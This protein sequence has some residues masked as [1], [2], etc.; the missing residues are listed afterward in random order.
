MLTRLPRFRFGSGPAA[1]VLAL[2]VVFIASRFVPAEPLF[3]EPQH[4]LALHSALEFFSIT[5]AGMVFALG[6]NLRRS[7]RGARLAWLG[8]VFLAVGLID[9]GHT[10]SYPGMPVFVTPSS[11]DKAIHFWLAARLVA[12]VGLLLH[13]L[14]PE[15]R[16]SPVVAKGLTIAAIALA[17]AWGWVV[18]AHEDSLPRAFDP[19]VGVTPFKVVVEYGLVVLYLIAAVLLARR[20]VGEG[21]PTSCWLAAAAT[22]LALAELYFTLYIEVT[23]LFNVLGHAYKVVAFAMIYRAVFVAGVRDPQDTLARERALLRGVIDSVPDLI[24]FRDTRGRYLGC[25]KAF[26]EAYGLDEARIIGLSEA[27]LFP[28][29]SGARRRGHGRAGGERARASRGMARGQGW[30]PAPARH[31]AYALP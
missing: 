22:V 26:A 11:A 9:F 5:V 30:P 23:D 18:L 17:L 4:Y 8:A 6:W 20:G 16:G 29:A 1:W 7:A 15:R 19:G 13:A 10:L 27:E 25:N 21:E 2:L 24:A 14:L 28:G 12:A 3:E 31:L